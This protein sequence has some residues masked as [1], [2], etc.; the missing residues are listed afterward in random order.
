[1][2]IKEN[3]KWGLPEWP[4]KILMYN[5]FFFGL[6]FNGSASIQNAIFNPLLEVNVS[7]VFTVFGIICFGLAFVDSLYSLSETPLY[8]FKLRIFSKALLLSVCHL[9]PI[10]IYSASFALDILCLIIEYR[11]TR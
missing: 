9:S 3:K 8:F 6:V 2:K 7:A 1:M 11:F 10:Y 4:L 5:F